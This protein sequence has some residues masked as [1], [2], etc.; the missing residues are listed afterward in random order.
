MKIGWLH[1]V[2]NGFT[3]TYENEE[4]KR[5]AEAIHLYRDFLIGEREASE[6]AYIYDGNSESVAYLADIVEKL[7]IAEAGNHIEEHNDEAIILR[8]IKRDMNLKREE[9]ESELSVYN[10]KADAKELND[11]EQTV[12]L[13]EVTDM[14]GISEEELANTCKLLDIDLFYKRGEN[15]D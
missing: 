12:T 1:I 14:L 6:L 7:I 10:W 8:E 9:I 5:F 4:E 13:E 2:A 3:I 15:N 11:N